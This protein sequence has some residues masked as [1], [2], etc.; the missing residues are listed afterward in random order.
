M[1]NSIAVLAL[2]IVASAAKPQDLTDI[3]K[4]E[5]T[6][7]PFHFKFEK[8]EYSKKHVLITVRVTN[9]EKLK[10]TFPTATIRKFKAV[11]PGSLVDNNGNRYEAFYRTKSLEKLLPETSGLWFIYLP[12]PIRQADFL[13]LQIGGQSPDLP[14]TRYKIDKKYWGQ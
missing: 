4:F 7:P 9:N 3:T 1:Q 11:E 2:L 8:I 12:T 14:V 6:L 5:H 10:F 13:V